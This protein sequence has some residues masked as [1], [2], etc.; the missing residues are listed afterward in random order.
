MN[1][2]ATDKKFHIDNY[3]F[4]PPLF[5]DIRLIQIGKMH[6]TGHTVIEEHIQHENQFELTA[7]TDGK[8]TVITNNIG[9]DIHAGEIYLSLPGDLHCIKS[10]TETPL[11]FLFF[12]FSPENNEMYSMLDKIIKSYASPTERILSNENI[13]Y[14]L[15]IAINEVN[16]PSDFSNQIMSAIFS[17]IVWL[18]IR[19]FLNM[20][21][22][23][24]SFHISDKAELCYC[25]MNYINTHIY[26][27][28]R[29]S[30]ISDVFSYNYSYLSDLFKNITGDT[31]Q[32]YYTTRRLHTASMLLAEGINVKKTA[33]MLQYSSMYSFSR[34]FKNVYG[35]SPSKYRR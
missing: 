22:K 28:T 21:K 17:H 35:V 1:K 29:L 3:Y 9:T 19:D 24:T 2:S 7:A 32:N 18:I 14:L 26:S 27:I 15:G 4:P 11:K 25:L 8:G 23:N 20:D 31:L 10:H 30:D 34:A 6:C 5:G 12:T 13:E 33:E 16:N